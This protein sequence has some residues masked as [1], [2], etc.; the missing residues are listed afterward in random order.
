M[1]RFREL[2][3][4]PEQPDAGKTG[5]LDTRSSR[6]TGLSN[7]PLHV[8]GVQVGPTRRGDKS[9]RVPREGKGDAVHLIKW[10]DHTAAAPAEDL[11]ML[12]RRFLLP[13][14]FRLTDGEGRERPFH[15]F[16][17]D[18]NILVIRRVPVPSHGPPTGL[19]Q[20]LLAQNRGAESVTVR[21]FD[22][23]SP[24][25]PCETCHRPNIVFQGEDLL[26]ICDSDCSIYRQFGLVGDDRFFVVRPDRCVIDAGTV[27]E[28]SLGEQRRRDA[29]SSR[30][31]IAPASLDG[32]Q[33]QTRR[34][35]F[36]G[37]VPL[38]PYVQRNRLIT[39]RLP[40]RRT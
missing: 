12:R 17:A 7:G 39:R 2:C 23:R 30:D 14:D 31:R 19:L 8:S 3:G 1:P 35:F 9:K 21:G 6:H 25:R 15:V 13:P 32:Q 33:A 38:S 24:D 26:T 4:D 20:S 5:S 34:M 10:F 16:L 37:K 40:K 22:V 18:F 36:F 27:Q 11:M 28:I 29:R